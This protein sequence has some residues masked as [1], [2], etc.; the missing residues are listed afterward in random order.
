MMSDPVLFQ[1]RMSRMIWTKGSGGRVME[2]FQRPGKMLE[3]SRG[4]RWEGDTIAFVPTMGALHEGHLS[5]V[6]LAAERADCVVTSIFVNPTQFGPLDDFNEYPRDLQSDLKVLSERNV[7]AVFLPETGDIYPAGNSTWVTEEELSN[8][9]EGVSRP[10]HFRGVTTVVAKLL[11]IVEPDILVVGQKDAQQAAVIKRMMHDLIYPVELITGKTVREPD[12]L[13]FS[14]RNNFLTVEERQQAV[15]LYE[16]LML[17]R[18]M[19]AGGER[20]CSVIVSAMRQRIEKEPSARID[21]IAAVDPDTFDDLEEMSAST[22]ISIA[23]FVGDTRL[24]D[25]ELIDGGN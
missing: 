10:G 21:Y 22:L 14:S 16:S 13:A 18:E 7:D 19:A 1:A 4:K 25:N 12:G 11:T 2:Q 20:N 5:L 17:A 3:W 15:S 23:V 6:D 8:R 9:L 24:I